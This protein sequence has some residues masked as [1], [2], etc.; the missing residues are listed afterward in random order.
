[1][2]LT[3]A[4]AKSDLDICF[5]DLPATITYQSQGEPTIDVSTGASTPNETDVVVTAVRGMYSA[6]DV[7]KANGFLEIGDVF[8]DIRKA[9]LDAE[10]VEPN[11]SDTIVDG[12]ETFQVFAWKL[13]TSELLYKISCRSVS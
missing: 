10:P 11:K 2:N 9:D 7:A 1:M 5:T 8:F 13:D 6:E 12:T 4:Q 3:E